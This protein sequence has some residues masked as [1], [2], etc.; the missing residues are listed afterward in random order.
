[1]CRLGRKINYL[2]IKNN[3]FYL[4]IPVQRQTANVSDLCKCGTIRFLKE[5]LH[6]CR[7]IS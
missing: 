1:M 5:D 3:L 4:D 6:F 2:L 7:K